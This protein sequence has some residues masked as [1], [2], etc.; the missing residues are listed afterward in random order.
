MDERDTIPLG[1]G[2]GGRTSPP[3]VPTLSSNDDSNVLG[4]L[5]IEKYTS[6]FNDVHSTE[7]FDKCDDALNLLSKAHGCEESSSFYHMIEIVI[8]ELLEMQTA[9]VVSI[10]SEFLC[11][12]NPDCKDEKG[13]NLTYD[14]RTSL[15][16]FWSFTTADY[17]VAQ[18]IRQRS[19]YYHLEIFKKVDVIVTLT[20]NMTSPIIPPSALKSRETNMQTTGVSKNRFGKK[21]KPNRFRTGLIS[22]VFK[23][24]LRIGF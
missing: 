10:G 13:V 7:I 4:S 11:S 5:R 2:D 21:T 23:P 12:L 14:T 17:V 18:C 22:L 24:N 3:C 16:L 9:H 1:H 8:P 20:T 6:W 19:M 15:A